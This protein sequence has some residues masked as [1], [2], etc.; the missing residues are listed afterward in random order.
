MGDPN[1][2]GIKWNCS[3]KE[4][5]LPL[6]GKY[7]EWVWDICI[8][9][10]VTGEFKKLEN[11]KYMGLTAAVWKVTA[12]GKEGMVWREG[13]FLGGLVVNGKK[14]TSYVNKTYYRNKR[15]S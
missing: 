11:F 12:F 3:Y 5:E 9:I 2:G 8:G 14:R 4:Q 15:W 1:N 13:M 6:V 10:L 7:W